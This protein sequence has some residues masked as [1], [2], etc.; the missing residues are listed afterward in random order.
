V[1]VCVFVDGENLRHTICDL[2]EPAFDRRDYLPKTADWTRFYDTVVSLATK[3]MGQRL[4][5]YWY[6]VEHVD[7]HPRPQGARKR[8]RQDLDRWAKK[9]ERQLRD[10]SIPSG[11]GRIDRLL[12]I[13]E[14]LSGK[15]NAIRARFDGFTNLQNGI[16]MKHRAIE[17]RR[18]GGIPYNLITGRFGEGTGAS[19]SIGMISDG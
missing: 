8:T 18:S 14:E 9:F 11:E 10:C 17:F 2:F 3:D 16:S 1:R 5:I 12:A 15:L 6:V 19:T 7:A 13:Q 4:R